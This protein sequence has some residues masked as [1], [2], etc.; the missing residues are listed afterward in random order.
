MSGQAKS[1]LDLVVQVLESRNGQWLYRHQ[2]RDQIQLLDQRYSERA[3]HR[4]LGSLAGSS[5]FE[6][7]LGSHGGIMYRYYNP[8]VPVSTKLEFDDLSIRPSSEGVGDWPE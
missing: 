5:G 3:I 4:A 7:K 8:N 1:E 6:E 2:I